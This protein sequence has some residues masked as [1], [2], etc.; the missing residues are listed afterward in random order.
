MLVNSRY[1]SRVRGVSRHGD[2]AI[3][4]LVSG[5]AGAH[6]DHFAN[7]VRPKHMRKRKRRSDVPETNLMVE[8]V[9]PGGQ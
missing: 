6:F 2:H 8:P 4:C 1:A 3:A 5:H 7:G 9:D